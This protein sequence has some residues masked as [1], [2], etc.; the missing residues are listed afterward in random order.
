VSA[1]VELLITREGNAYIGNFYRIVAYRAGDDLGERI[2][3][4]YSKRESVRLA[5]ALIA[6]RGR[7][8]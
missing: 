4:G 7:L 3:A 8:D 6:D 2:Y 1:R 5:R